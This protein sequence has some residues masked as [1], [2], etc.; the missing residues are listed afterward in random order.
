[1]PPTPTLAA[2]AGLSQ[3]E[4]V[5]MVMALAGRVESL[6]AENLRLRAELAWTPTLGLP[7]NVTA[8]RL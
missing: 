2:V 4:L 5:E 6:E 8:A 1:L 7:L 3:A